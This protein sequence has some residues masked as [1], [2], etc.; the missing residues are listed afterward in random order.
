MNF[1]YTKKGTLYGLGLGFLVIVLIFS[2]FICTGITDFCGSV[3]VSSLILWFIDV[4]YASISSF[5]AGLFS[6]SCSG[7]D[8][9]GF[10]F[11]GMFVYPFFIAT[12][13]GI[14]GFFVDLYFKHKRSNNINKA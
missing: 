11:I 7:F 3:Y 13:G 8:C 6:G 2:F 14:I 10:G 4:F 1:H 9:F 5:T 12:I